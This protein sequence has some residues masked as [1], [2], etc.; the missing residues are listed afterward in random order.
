[1]TNAFICEAHEL[2][3]A[4]GFEPKTVLTWVKPGIGMG[5]YFRN[6][7][8]HVLFAVR[9][10]LKGLR[11]DLPTGFNWPRGRHSEKPAAFYDMVETMSPGPRLDVF[12]R[13]KR[14]GWD[15]Y[16]NE[17]YSDIPLDTPAEAVGS[18]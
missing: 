5:F 10:G 14:F 6:N 8:E 12:A 9:G 16:G 15:V 18:G 1:M 17:V 13:A 7:T 2:A 3:L 4:W 11:R